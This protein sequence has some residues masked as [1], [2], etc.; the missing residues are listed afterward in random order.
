MAKNPTATSIGDQLLSL[1][2]SEVNVIVV[3]RQVKAGRGG[4]SVSIRRTVIC[5]APADDDEAN[6]VCKRLND[7]FPQTEG[8]TIGVEKMALFPDLDSF[9][10]LVGKAQ[11]R[12]TNLA[13]GKALAA[14]PA[15]AQATLDENQKALIA[16]YEA[17]VEDETEEAETEEAETE[18]VAAA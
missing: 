10:E 17:S 2:D 13:A 12:E 14:L 7:V 3:K 15:A 4:K 8:A 1:A 5:A 18:E 16:A 6:A 9:D 11:E